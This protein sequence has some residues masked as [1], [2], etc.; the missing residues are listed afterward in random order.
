MN[1]LFDI[2]VASATRVYLD[3]AKVKGTPLEDAASSRQQEAS[4]LTLGEALSGHGMVESIV[5]G[6][7]Q[8]R[9][10]RLVQRVGRWA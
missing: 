3:R 2:I 9:R 7:R 4:C 5:P 10:Y 6:T 8:S 1:S